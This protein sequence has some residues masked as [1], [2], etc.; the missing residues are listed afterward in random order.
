MKSSHAA[1]LRL[2]L[3]QLMTEFL[4]LHI[5]CGGYSNEHDEDFKPVQYPA[6]PA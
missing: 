1:D 3:H 6:D 4:L 5:E 2:P